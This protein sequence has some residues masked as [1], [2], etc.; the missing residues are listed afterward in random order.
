MG[1]ELHDPA[2]QTWI[3]N[4]LSL[5]QAI[6]CPF[7]SSIS[8]VFQA[9]KHILVACAAISF[10]GCAIAPGASSIYRVIGAQTMIGFGFAC[11]PLALSVPSE[12]VPRR[13][14]PRMFKF[15]YPTKLSRSASSDML[16]YR[17]SRHDERGS[18]SWSHGGPHHYRGFDQEQFRHRLEELLCKVLS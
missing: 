6:I 4:S 15:P 13:W 9:R 2:N 16:V 14:R 18:F 8:D 3:P 12:I 1:Q 7:L 10:I 17:G 11:I 5:V